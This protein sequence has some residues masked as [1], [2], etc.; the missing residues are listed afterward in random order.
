MSSR[1]PYGILALDH[2]QGTIKNCDIFENKLAGIKILKEAIPVIHHC[3]IHDELGSG[4]IVCEHGQGTIEDCE[5]FHCKKSG[6]QIYSQGNPIIRRC[7][8]HDVEYGVKGYDQGQGRI[9]DCE[10]F[11]NRYG[12]DITSEANPHIHGCKIHNN[13]A[14][15]IDVTGNGRGEIAECEIIENKDCGVSISSGSP[16]IFHCRISANK[17]HAIKVYQGQGRIENCDLRGNGSG[18]WEIYSKCIIKRKNN[19]EDY[20]IGVLRLSYPIIILSNMVILYFFRT[21]VEDMI[22][23]IILCTLINFFFAILFW[24]D[25]DEYRKSFIKVGIHFAIL[26]ISIFLS[27]Y[28]CLY[29]LLIYSFQNPR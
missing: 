15:G 2:G 6:I 18:A 5:F 29:K 22:G 11:E 28:F 9:E 14:H 23:N 4:V 21:G 10:I 20:I 7:K 13:R 19:R 17:N 24:I 25:I 12:V 3:S 27:S 1:K 8:I 16:V 26:I